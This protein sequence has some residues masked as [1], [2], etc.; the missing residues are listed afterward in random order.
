[1]PR[2]FENLHYAIFA[3]GG[4]R[5][6][7]LIIRL[8]V[9]LIKTLYTL[10]AR[11]TYVYFVQT[12]FKGLEDAEYIRLGIK[13]I[14]APLRRILYYYYQ[15]DYYLGTPPRC[16][17]AGIRPSIDTAVTAARLAILPTNIC[18]EL[19]CARNNFRDATKNANRI[20]LDT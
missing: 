20:R 8:T 1:M 19:Y 11:H 18:V 9:D 5:R 4:T 6:I 2:L 12:R 7:L 14:V 3:R 15:N 13:R 17:G 10:G 16:R